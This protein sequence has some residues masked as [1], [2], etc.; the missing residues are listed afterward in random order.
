[1]KQLL[2]VAML[3]PILSF[4]QEV[5]PILS[6]DYLA[7]ITY[8]SIGTK[9]NKTIDTTNSIEKSSLRYL[10]KT[11]S[12]GAVIRNIITSG[13]GVLKLQPLYQT[14]LSLTGTATSSFLLQYA[15]GV[16]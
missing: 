14:Y 1:M 12:N 7:L 6:K 9:K 4:A 11:Y 5:Q 16:V 15:G 13:D 3:L 10:G 8:D 2:L